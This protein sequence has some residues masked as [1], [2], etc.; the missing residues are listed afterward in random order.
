[1]LFAIKYYER[2]IGGRR[3]KDCEKSVKIMNLS[4]KKKK[5]C[6]Y[7]YIYIYI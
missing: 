5:L 6:I 1:M 7:I 3:I 2:K 4:Q